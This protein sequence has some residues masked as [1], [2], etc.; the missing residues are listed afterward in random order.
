[1]TETPNPAR[2]FRA[3]RALPVTFALLALAVLLL[4]AAARAQPGTTYRVTITNLTESQPITPPVVVTHQAGLHLFVAGEAAPEPLVPLAEDGDFMPLLEALE[5]IRIVHQATVASDAPIPPGG[6]ATV[7]IQ[8][9]GKAVYLSAVGMLATTNDTFFGLDS[10]YLLGHPW[11]RHVEVPAYDA[12]S[13]EDNEL[14]EFIPGPPCENPFV[15]AT[16]NAE[17]FVHLS[18]GID[19]VGDLESAM[20]SWNNPVVRID[21]VR[22]P[23]ARGGNG[24]G[25]GNN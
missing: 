11:N 5:E 21:V 6:S 24:N 13:E 20:W 22:L 4:P 23:P 10:F 12:G 2:R 16:E 25:N 9:R 18:S 1:M 14:C 8:A 3:L 19:G 7:E 15:R 17:G